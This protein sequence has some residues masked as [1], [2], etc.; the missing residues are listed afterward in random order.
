M[1]NEEVEMPTIRKGIKKLLSSYI[2]HEQIANQRPGPGSMIKHSNGS[3]AGYQLHGY[4]RCRMGVAEA[5]WSD[6]AR[7][8]NHV[9]GCKVKPRSAAGQSKRQGGCSVPT[10]RAAVY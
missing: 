6:V 7:S 10:L 1:Q 4:S 5:H 8:V 2:S 3:W 9:C